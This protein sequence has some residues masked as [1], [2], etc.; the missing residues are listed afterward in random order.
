MKV[1][2]R[3]CLSLAMDGSTVPILTQKMKKKKTT[4]ER[5]SL[6]IDQGVKLVNRIEGLNLDEKKKDVKKYIIED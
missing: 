4:R 5:L 1:L 6:A 2:A 3:E